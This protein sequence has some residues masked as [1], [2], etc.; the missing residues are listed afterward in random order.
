[1]P[2]EFDYDVIQKQ[3]NPTSDVEEKENVE[4]DEEDD[5]FSMTPRDVEGEDEDEEESPEGDDKDVK[6]KSPE[7]K[8]PTDAEAEALKSAVIK[9][10]G[11]DF[12]LN[13][14][15]NVR[16]LK[17]VPAD[18]L[19]NGLQKAFR[20]DQIFNELSNARKQF[21]EE[22]RQFEEQKSQQEATLGELKTRLNNLMKMNPGNAPRYNQFGQPETEDVSPS[23]YDSPE[24]RAYKEEVART[25]ERLNTLESGL[26]K[27]SQEAYVRSIKNEIESLAKDYPLAP[28]DEI[29]A[30]KLVKPEVKT[31]EL[32]Q[33]A[34]DYYRADERIDIAIRSNPEYMK[35]LEEQVI[36]N[37][38]AR[39]QSAK[40]VTGVQKSSSGSE[41]SF[42]KGNVPIRDF[43][44]A[45]AAARGFL[46]EMARSDR[47]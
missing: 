1:M 25:Q 41:K 43:K 3:L 17:D 32:L 38:L 13:I 36:K 14:K 35:K 33:A 42:T 12:S 7:K 37:Y 26:N 40:K 16:S 27:S 4:V 39:R 28:V 31:E 34:H 9:Q 29:L 2:G 21:E 15:G 6:E 24:T 19:K 10:Y 47:D 5:F 45:D 22:R 23:P 44:Q 46:R 20:G 11:E 8:E 30:I 18:E